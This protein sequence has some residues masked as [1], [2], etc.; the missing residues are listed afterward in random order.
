M[1]AFQ[2]HIGELTPNEGLASVLQ[3]SLKPENQE[4]QSRTFLNQIHIKILTADIPIFI[5]I[6]LIKFSLRQ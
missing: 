2:S 3:M 6:T 4:F 5:L 1:P